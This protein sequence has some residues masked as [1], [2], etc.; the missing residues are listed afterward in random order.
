MTNTSYL[1]RLIGEY[2]AI[3][4]R[5]SAI[6]DLAQQYQ[7]LNP[8][9]IEEATIVITSQQSQ[10]LARLQTQVA[11][12]LATRQQLLEAINQHT[13]ANLNRIL[14]LVEA[15]PPRETITASLDRLLTNSYS[16]ADVEHTTLMMFIVANLEAMKHTQA[17]IMSRGPD[18]PV[19]RAYQ[20]VMYNLLGDAENAHLAL[21]E[22]QVADEERLQRLGTAGL[23]AQADEARDQA[24]QIAAVEPYHYH[25]PERILTDATRRS[26]EIP[27]Y[28]AMRPEAE[29]RFPRRVQ[30]DQVAAATCAG[31]H[32]FT[33]TLRKTGQRWL[34]R[35]DTHAAGAARVVAQQ[36]LTAFQEHYEHRLLPREYDVAH[37]RVPTPELYERAVAP[38][39]TLIEATEGRHVAP[40]DTPGGERYYYQSA[41]LAAALAAHAAALDWH[42]A[43]VIQPKP[44]QRYKP[45][46]HAIASWVHEDAIRRILH[47]RPTD[48]PPFEQQ[49]QQGRQ[50]LLNFDQF[51]EPAD[52]ICIQQLRP[53]IASPS[54]GSPLDRPQP[55]YMLLEPGTHLARD[56]HQLPQDAV[57]SYQYEDA[58]YHKRIGEPYS[59]EIDPQAAKQHSIDILQ[60]VQN[61]LTH[62]GPQYTQHLEQ[63]A[64][65]SHELAA[66]GLQSIY[67]STL[68]A[69]IQT[70]FENIARSTAVHRIIDELTGY[71]PA[72]AAFLKGSHHSGSHFLDDQHATALVAAARAAGIT[73]PAVTE[74]CHRL[75]FTARQQQELNVLQRFTT[76]RDRAHEVT[77]AILQTGAQ[78]AQ[79]AASV[80]AAEMGWT[81]EELQDAQGSGADDTSRPE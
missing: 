65:T 60:E 56:P 36:F 35:H 69:V 43:R 29:T 47:H 52:I 44:R 80:A 81:L 5:T 24:Y 49:W 22:F 71:R 8:D 25:N 55:E 73:E 66:A 10:R 21:T 63:I 45:E 50:A 68:E 19:A 38:A 70:I 61:G 77:Q 27:I 16:N 39:H 12:R 64:L 42:I 17:E 14:D 31:A 54:V 18:D 1:H 13:E 15:N 72:A 37:D 78:H 32:I 4:Q 33:E 51:E 59:H 26:L 58:Y 20:D 79:D 48:V 7:Y 46:H 62:C 75:D 9:L 3:T 76:T 2:E 34:R 6:L 67:G 23:R 40:P 30:S 41:V 57:I 28:P 53:E 74:M 11:N